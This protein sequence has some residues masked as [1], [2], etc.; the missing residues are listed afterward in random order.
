MNVAAAAAGSD[1]YNGR[2]LY[3]DVCAL[4]M[5][6][7]DAEGRV[8]MGRGG[9][10]YA[11]FWSLSYT[12]IRDRILGTGKVSPEELDTFI[13]LFDD[14]ELVWAWAWADVNDDACVPWLD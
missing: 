13:A 4:G 9:T 6:D 1:I 5:V 10:P 3:A 2:R 14:P 7:V 12:Q 11:Q 8:H